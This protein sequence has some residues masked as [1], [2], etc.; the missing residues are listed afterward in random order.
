MPQY[1][2]EKAV[3][4]ATNDEYERR[5]AKTEGKSGIGR[6]R[7]RL[8]W[9]KR[10]MKH[11]GDVHKGAL[12]AANKY[13]KES[14]D[15]EAAVAMIRTRVNKASPAQK[16]AMKKSLE[17]AMK[18]AK[19][20]ANTHRLW[21][22]RVQKAESEMQKLRQSI[23]KN[24]AKLNA[25]LAARPAKAATHVN[26]GRKNSKGRV[27]HKSQSGALFVIVDGKKRYLK[28]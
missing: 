24:T 16:E 19:V 3:R 11:A 7:E 13:G 5:R 26:T 18:K 2:F 23:A 8:N 22:K 10:H 6:T 20:A 28:K 17:N 27:I 4:G 12:A 1:P 14:R 25:K 15:A 9:Q 21:K